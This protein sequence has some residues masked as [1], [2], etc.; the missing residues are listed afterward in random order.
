MALLAREKGRPDPK[1]ARL[2]GRHPQFG[3]PLNDLHDEA[4]FLA[5]EQHSGPLMAQL[6]EIQGGGDHGGGRH[7]PSR[8]QR[9]P[10]IVDEDDH[11]ARNG[12]KR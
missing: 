11:Q 8:D 10:R 2:A 4:F 5:A 6:A 1:D 7:Q 3:D 12:K 9:Q